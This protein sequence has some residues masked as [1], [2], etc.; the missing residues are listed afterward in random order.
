MNSLRRESSA[1]HVHTGSPD[2]HDLIGNA[3]AVA[4]ILLNRR[5]LT[6]TTFFVLHISVAGL[7]VAFLDVLPQLIWDITHRFQT[8]NYS[9][10][11]YY[12]YY[13]T[14]ILLLLLVAVAKPDFSS[15]PYLY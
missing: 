1:W 2:Y 6:R 8:I 14:T 10:L 15:R 3:A 5:R 7:V 13:S 11:Y 12:Y 4:V 9:I